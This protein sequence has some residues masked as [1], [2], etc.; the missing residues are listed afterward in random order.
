AA[1][2]SRAAVGNPGAAAVDVAY[3]VPIEASQHAWDQVEGAPYGT[4]GGIGVTH[5]FPTEGEYVFAIE[6][7]LGQKGLNFEAREIAL[8][9]A[10]VA[11][12]ALP[13][14][15]GPRAAADVGGASGGYL[16]TPPILVPS[17]QHRVSATFI[18]K[19]EGPYDDR[20]ITHE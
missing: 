2:I 1:D 16:T 10:P 4:R 14:N 18:R 8:A 15:A 19:I 13:F 11:Q 5:D 17:G 12:L 7:A 3:N 9:G 20:F 6:T